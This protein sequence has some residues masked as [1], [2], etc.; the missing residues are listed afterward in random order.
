ML[1]EI[2]TKESC[3]FCDAVK[4]LLQSM[5]KEYTEYNLYTDFSKEEFMEKF[6]PPHTFP[7]VLVD[8]NLV[9]GYND[10]VNFIKDKSL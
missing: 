6:Q 9:G 7:R 3:P 1:I 8:G 10:F 4:S 5:N 2:Y